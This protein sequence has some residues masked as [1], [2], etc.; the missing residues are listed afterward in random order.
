MIFDI[1]ILEKDSFMSQSLLN[2][3]L[4]ESDPTLLCKEISYHVS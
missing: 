3:S 4:Q 1:N 2:H